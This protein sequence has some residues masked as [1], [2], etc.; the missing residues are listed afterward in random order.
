MDDGYGLNGR[1]GVRSDG[2]DIGPD[3]DRYP[4]TQ[5]TPVDMLTTRFNSNGDMEVE[6]Q[7][8]Y[9]SRPSNVIFF[10][11][12]D[13]STS[14]PEFAHTESEVI[15]AADERFYSE[16][17]RLKTYEPKWLEDYPVRP[18]DLARNGFIHI[19]PG[20]KVKCVFCLR[21]L[22]H[23]DHNDSVEMEHWK[24]YPDCPFVQGKCDHLNVPLSLSENMK[25]S[26]G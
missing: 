19:G 14:I 21:T 12:L 4:F 3:E 23:W 8:V 7:Q 25:K 2:H 17:N 1:S 26:F 15:R 20:D 11:P 22:R 10:E 9:I 6:H 18:T 5:G 24:H 13:E 16:A